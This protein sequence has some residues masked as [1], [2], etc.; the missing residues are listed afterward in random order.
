[1]GVQIGR[2]DCEHCGQKGILGPETKCTNCGANR[3]EDVRFYLPKNAQYYKDE[4][5]LKA[6]KAGANWDCSFCGSDNLATATHC[7]SCSNPRTATEKRLEV[8]EYGLNDVP[9]DSEEARGLELKD[10]RARGLKPEHP[11]T[12]YRKAFNQSSPPKKTNKTV[13]WI[14]GFFLF[15]FIILMILTFMQK[16]ISVEVTQMH[17]ERT[18]ETEQYKEVTEEGWKVPSGGRVIDSYRAVHHTEKV[19]DG[20]ETRTREAKRQVGTEEY[21]CG[22]RDLGNGYFEDKYC[23]RPVYETYTEEYQVQRYREEPVYRTKYRYAIFKW[24]PAANINS[25]GNDK[26]PE[27]GDTDLI[28]RDKNRRERNRTEV[29]SIQVQDEK[30]KTHEEKLSFSRWKTINRGDQLKARRNGLGQYQGIVHD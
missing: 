1:M 27:W 22:K 26:S 12:E 16:E 28:D 25:S 19:P 3:P 18:I 7:R 11:E 9:E 14:G 5:N 21:V 20:Y 17:W 15:G 30:G 6:A 4:K 10:D 13:L 24:V 2:W 8:R 29:Y 23:S